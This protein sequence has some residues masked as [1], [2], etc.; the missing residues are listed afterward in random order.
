VSHNEL[1]RIL[2]H[3]DAWKKTRNGQTYEERI[4]DA[5]FTLACIEVT[6]DTSKQHFFT[7]ETFGGDYCRMC[8]RNFRHTQH[9]RSA[10]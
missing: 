10:R 2:D 7:P 9:I 1:G 5:E 6:A 8:G 3:I 4:E